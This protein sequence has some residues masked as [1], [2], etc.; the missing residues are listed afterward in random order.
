MTGREIIRSL[1]QDKTCPERMGL[2]ED[3]W[4]DTRAAWELEGLPHGVD[5][6]DY[7]NYDLQFIDG[8]WVN[9]EA[10]VDARAIVEEDDRTYVELNGWGARMRYWKNKPG[11][12]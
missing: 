11:T 9:T 1:V 5:L 10:L 8:E 6:H 3:F 7:F 4:D 12:P 2:F